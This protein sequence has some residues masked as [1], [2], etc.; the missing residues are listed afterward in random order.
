MKRVGRST[1]F[2]ARKVSVLRPYQT[3]LKRVD[4]LDTAGTYDESRAE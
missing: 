2:L 1:P 3:D 4:W